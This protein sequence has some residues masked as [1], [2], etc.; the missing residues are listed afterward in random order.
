M[1]ITL[2]YT[3]EMKSSRSRIKP[4]YK[5]VSPEASLSTSDTCHNTYTN[6]PN[7]G[8]EMSAYICCKLKQ[9]ALYKNV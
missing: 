8:K 3:V 6:K 4:P 9:M 2:R 1:I 7:D 5:P